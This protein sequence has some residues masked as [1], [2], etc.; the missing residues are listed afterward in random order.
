[1]YAHSSKLYIYFVNMNK[2]IHSKLA[3]KYS[4]NTEEL[5]ESQANSLT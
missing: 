5:S 4:I 1:M 2:I 3:F